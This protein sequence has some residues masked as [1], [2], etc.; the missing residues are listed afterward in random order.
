MINCASRDI[1][2]RSQFNT[3][4]FIWTSLSLS[5]LKIRLN[6]NE[7]ENFHTWK[8][9]PEVET[10]EVWSLLCWSLWSSS[11]TNIKSLSSLSFFARRKKKKIDYIIK[12]FKIGLLFLRL[13][14]WWDFGT[15]IP[16]AV[17]V[18]V[19]WTKSGSGKSTRNFKSVKQHGTKRLNL[20]NK[21]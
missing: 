8:G 4:M 17:P 7:I 20:T 5:R 2:Q 6:L 18:T 19:I 16:T 3:I 12:R 14:D 13:F 11:I 10:K 9:T 1:T 21:L 15:P